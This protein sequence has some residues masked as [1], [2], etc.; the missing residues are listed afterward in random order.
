MGVIKDLSNTR[1]HSM[2]GISS[3][4]VKTVYKKSLAHWRGQKQKQSSAFNLGSAVHALLL[5]EDKDL[6]VKGPKTKTSKA[7]KELEK[8]LQE[9]QILLSEA[10]YYM[11]HKMAKSALENNKCGKALRHKDRVNEVSIF[12]RCPR[13]GLELK[14]RPDLMI[15]EE[16]AVYDVKTTIDASP[17]GFSKECF[18]YAYDIQA[19]FYKYVIE[20]AGIEVKEFS[21]I[22]CE[23]S[24]PYV[25]HMHVVSSDL[26]NNAT[27]RMHDTLDQIAF[28]DLSLDYGTGWGNY[29]VIDLPKWL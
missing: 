10:E 16:G 8:E 29:S 19:A 1:Y 6:V 7:F 15:T 11:A 28:A 27:K 21:F 24:S 25:S 9:D 13:S 17:S 14:T 12:E 22:A 26:L 4:A 3:S 5:E 20:L 18:K 23:K 2:D